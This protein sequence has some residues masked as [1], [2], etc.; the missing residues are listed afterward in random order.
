MDS[1]EKGLKGENIG[2]YDFFQDRFDWALGKQVRATIINYKSIIGYYNCLLKN[3]SFDP[4]KHPSEELVN[5][6]RNSYRHFAKLQRDLRKTPGRGEYF[7]EKFK[8]IR[9]DLRTRTIE[10]LNSIDDK[11][12]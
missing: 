7:K 5:I 2:L 6:L 10:L 11:L 3:S 4:E 1:F 12:S 8:P 9:E